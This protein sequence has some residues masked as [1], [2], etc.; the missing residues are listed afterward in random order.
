[1]LPALAAGVLPGS[2][3]W[4]QHLLTPST[5]SAG[6]I[7]AAAGMTA[8]AIVVVDQ[9]EELFTAG[10]DE[11]ERAG[12]VGEVLAVLDREPPTSR[13]VVTIRADYLG[14]CAVYPALADHLGEGTVLVGPMSDEEVRR[15][16]E[17]PAWHAGLR[18]EPDLV[19]AVIADVRGRAGALPLLST[20]LLDTWERRRG[21]T[22]THAGYL[23]AGGVSGA[24]ARLADAAY[25]RL[26][27]PQ[28]QAARRIFLRLAETGEAGAPVRRRV[29]RDEIAPPHDA[30]A[31]G[32]LDVLVARRLVSVDEQTVEVAHEALLSH[33]PRLA[34]WLED[35]TQGRALRRHLTP[36]AREWAQAG[37]PDAELYRGARLATALDWA[38][39][40]EQDMHQMEREFLEASRAAADRELRAERERADREAHARRRLR[41]MLAALSVLLLVA[42]TATAVAVHQRGQARDAARAAEARRLGARAMTESTLDRSLLLAIEGVR[43]DPSPETKSDLLAALLRSPHAIAQV[44]GDGD[45]LQDLALS[46]DGGTLA[47]GDNNGTV[48]LWD[49]RTMRQL[50]GPLTVGYWSGHV[51]FSPDSRQLAVLSASDRAG[52]RFELVLFNLAA[53]RPRLRLPAPVADIGQPGTATWTA[54][55]RTVAVGSGTGQLL[56]YD[57]ATGH[58]RARLAVPGASRTTEVNPIPAGA[59]L[60]ATADHD[61]LAILVDP[62]NARVL[63]RIQMPARPSGVGVSRD[64]RTLAIG[65]DQGGVYLQDLADGRVRRGSGGHRGPVRGLRFSSDGRTL[66][67]VSDDQNVIVW[68]VPSGRVLLTLAGHTGTVDGA[69]FS[70]DN[71]TL[72]TASLDE[73]VIAWDIFG[74]RSFGVTHPNGGLTAGFEPSMPISVAWSANKRRAAMGN[75]EGRLVS[76]DV[77]SGIATVQ[78]LSHTEIGGLALS[79]DG[80]FAYLVGPDGKVR[81]WNIVAARQDQASTLGSPESKGAIAVS[82]DGDRLVVGAYSEDSNRPEPVYLIDSTTLT[83]LRRIDPEFRGASDGLSFSGDGQRIAL[84]ASDKEGV[85]VFDAL[86]E[87]QVWT[88]R[89]FQ[90]VSVTNFS[91]DRRRLVV[92]SWNGTFAVFDAAT[93]RSLAGPAVAQPGP[94]RSASFSPDGRTILTSGADGTVRLW[95]ASTL[96]QIGLPLHPP[97]QGPLPRAFATFTPD[98]SHILALDRHARVTTWEATLPAWLHRAC[99]IVQREL[100]PNERVLFSITP[101]TPPACS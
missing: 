21:D 3:H 19:E 22:L 77:A 20:A 26:S 40:H 88:S 15:A 31:R 6:P 97:D 35:D 72:Y 23:A 85:A 79:P 100:T 12:F 83:P 50:A 42:A 17:G 63:R 86:T 95:D 58:Q 32:A 9:F 80:Q 48:V 66:A 33:W 52:T 46:P 69:A 55:G 75:W 2:D 57:A 14:R 92:G 71:R 1:L 11:A 24:L 81:R 59:Q 29:P 73:T 93:G 38:A 56:L 76:I 74:D 7:P 62:T 51:A 60:I 16:I 78:R 13:V 27:G 53:R 70:P 96:R 4:A 49:A 28:R 91:A 61:R 98:G 45:R 39:G 89:S 94:V 54:D 90:K 25:A 5:A 44:R 101:D 30:A 41:A 43:T 18:I 87:Q 84:G 8:A 37:W 65:D 68:N 34:R 99:S 67:S 47:A 64:G 10:R 82:P 36:A